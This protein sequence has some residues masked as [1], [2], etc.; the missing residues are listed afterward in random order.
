[1]IHYAVAFQSRH[2]REMSP[3]HICWSKMQMKPTPESTVARHQTRLSL[4]YGCM[5]LMVSQSKS[6][7]QISESWSMILSYLIL[8]IKLCSE[9]PLI[10]F[11]SCRY[12]RWTSR[13]NA[14]QPLIKIPATDIIRNSS[15]DSS[16]VIDCKHKFKLTRHR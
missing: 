5:C 6:L 8:T 10:E 9:S 16:G 14:Q 7:P 11:H 2:A 1:M 12:H 3:H 4:A 15:P 13:G